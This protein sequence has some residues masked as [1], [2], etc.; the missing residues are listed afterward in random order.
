MQPSAAV[1]RVFSLLET[2]FLKGKT[3]DYI[4]MQTTNK[5]SFRMKVTS[6]NWNNGYTKLE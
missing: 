5:L 1:E 6:L 3:Q 2:L 4:V